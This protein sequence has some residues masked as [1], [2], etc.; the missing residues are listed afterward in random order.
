LIEFVEE[1]PSRRAG[2]VGIAVD[3]DK[4]GSL[5]R[6]QVMASGVA[7][8]KG[9]VD[10]AAEGVRRAIGRLIEPPGSD[11]QEDVA[12]AYVMLIAIGAVAA[13]PLA[14]LPR[15]KSVAHRAGIMSCLMELSPVARAEAM[16]AMSQAMRR[17]PDP[18]LRASAGMC[19]QALLAT[20]LK[21][22][23]R[24]EAGYITHGTRGR[25]LRPSGGPV[26]ARRQPSSATAT[27]RIAVDHATTRRGFAESFVVELHPERLEAQRI[28][29]PEVVAQKPH[30]TPKRPGRLVAAANLSHSAGFS[31]A[32]LLP[33]TVTGLD[34]DPGYL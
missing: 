6:E 9:E 12:G 23:D 34:A 17:E 26:F 28:S 22:G 33:A 31:P 29:R 21:G 10:R 1:R 32:R 11:D 25:E 15:A 24:E 3:R 20:S 4:T 27:S 14:A 2:N 19:F 18:N 5:F 7:E 13:G 16:R 30:N 8:E